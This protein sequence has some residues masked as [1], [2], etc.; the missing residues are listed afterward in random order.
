MQNV[1]SC[2][3]TGKGGNHTQPVL[4]EKCTWMTPTPDTFGS[5]HVLAWEV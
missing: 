4:E 3:E 1:K 2:P 5:C